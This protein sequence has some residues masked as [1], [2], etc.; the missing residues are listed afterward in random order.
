[1][2]SPWRQS[3]DLQLRPVEG[4]S[5]RALDLSTPWRR[6]NADQLSEAGL[7]DQVEVVEVRRRGS[8]QAFPLAEPD[9]L[10]NAPDGG[11][12]LGDDQRGYFAQVSGS[13]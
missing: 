1:M 8:R 12:D 2:R 3:E 6:E 13:T 7:G 5:E 10:R 9:L 4:I 11:G